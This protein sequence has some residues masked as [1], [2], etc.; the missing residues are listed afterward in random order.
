MKGDRKP[1]PIFRM[2]PVRMTSSDLFKVMIIQR[3]ITW[4]WYNIQV[5]V[6]PFSSYLQWPTNRKS[7]MIYRTS[8][9]SVT[10]NGLY[11][12]FQG[13]AILWR[14]ISR[15][16]YDIQTQCHWNI[17]RDLHTPYATVSLR[18][19]LSDLQNIQWHEA[20]R[21]LSATTELLVSHVDISAW[22]CCIVVLHF[23]QI[24]SSSTLILAF[25]AL[26]F[27]GRCPPSWIC[28][29]VVGPRP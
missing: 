21:G 25:Y 1:H 14:W 8:P 11:P 26:A 13:H 22:S 5:Y 28:W 23:L 20:S 27:Y 3:Q 17:N 15:K 16:R 12:H 24:F 6:V 29:E 19:T 18:M 10:L 2:V 9:F 4:K 7:Y